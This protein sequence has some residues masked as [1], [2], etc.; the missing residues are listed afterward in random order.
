MEQ[1]FITVATLIL[2][3]IIVDFNVGLCLQSEADMLTW[4]DHTIIIIII[5]REIP[6]IILINNIIW[7]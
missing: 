1:F 4:G 5:N 6:T 3:L 7:C 2:E